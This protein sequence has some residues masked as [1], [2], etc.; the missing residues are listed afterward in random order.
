MFISA[1]SKEKDFEGYTLIFPAV[2]VGN[3]GQLAVDMI[4][5]TLWMERIG[6]IYHD[7]ILPLVGNDPFAHP[8]SISCKIVT[9]CEVYENTENK[10]II[11][12]QRSPFVQGKR[13]SF[14]QWLRKWMVEMK[15][16][17]LVILTSS[18]AHERIDSQLQGSQFRFVA[19][20]KFEKHEIEDMKS[21]LEWQELEKRLSENGET[22][23]ISSPYIPGGGIAKSLFKDCSEE[24]KVCILLLFC[25]E[26]DNASDALQ[27]AKHANSWLNIIDMEPKL[28]MGIDGKS[29]KMPGL[30]WKVPY[31]WKL[32]FGSQVD[33]T[34][35]H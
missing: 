12:Q 15:I 13:A 8:E 2:S 34:L 28:V 1:E 19:S 31:S 7:S 30:S 29:V 18:H 23:E 33:R 16:S 14:K 35:F 20:P 32:M 17:Q 6:Y 21:R 3:V 26:G 4:I 11:I 22:E 27:L 25:S 9:N 10:T 5:S 24:V